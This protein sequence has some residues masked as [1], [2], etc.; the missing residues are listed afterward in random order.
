M[1]MSIRIKDESRENKEGEDQWTWKNIDS[2][3]A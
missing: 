1:R 3:V 2:P